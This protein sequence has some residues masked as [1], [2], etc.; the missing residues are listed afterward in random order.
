MLFR[1]SKGVQT[2]G[3]HGMDF[4]R[5]PDWLYCDGIYDATFH[6]G[7]NGGFLGGVCEGVRSAMSL[8][9]HSSDLGNE[10]T[11]LLHQSTLAEALPIDPSI[12][13]RG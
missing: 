2:E 10:P 13:C 7:D 6:D 12:S 3:V 11:S 5:E 9:G 8:L 4:W 1:G